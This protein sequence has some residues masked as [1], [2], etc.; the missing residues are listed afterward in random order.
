MRWPEGVRCVKCGGDRISEFDTTGKTGKPRHLYECMD[1]KYQYS[2]T[3]GT[4]FHNSHVPLTKWFLAIYLMCTAKKGVS[5]KQ[6]ERQLGVSY[7]TAWS[8]GHRIRLAMQDGDFGGMT[9][10]KSKLWQASRGLVADGIVGSATRSAIGTPDTIREPPPGG[11]ISLLTSDGLD[12]VDSSVP[13][14]PG[15]IFEPV[16]IMLHHTAAGGTKDVPSL[17]VVRNGRPGLSGPLAPLLI[18]RGGT[19]YVTC[20][21]GGVCNHAGMGRGIV[22]V[23]VRRGEPLAPEDTSWGLR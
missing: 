23:K 17:N 14:R 6:L 21:Q 9:E 12:V 3:V 2:V 8:M 4:V 10:R 11:L 13:P 5:G 18:G 15:Q 22:L 7:E 16:G 20:D 1:C 19:I